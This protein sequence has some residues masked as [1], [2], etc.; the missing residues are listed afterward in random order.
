MFKVRIVNPGKKGSN[1]VSAKRNSKGQ[2]VKKGK[3]SGSR[4]RRRA[5]PATSNPA[6]SRRRRRRSSSSSSSS[7]RRRRRRRNPSGGGG[8]KG[9]NPLTSFPVK[10]LIPYIL[11]NLAQAFAVKRWGDPYGNSMLSGGHMDIS[12]FRGSAWS[13]KNYMIC[14]GVGYL[15]AKI[16]ARVGSLGGAE[17]GRIWWRSAVEQM[18]TRLIWTEAISRMDWAKNNFAGLPSGGSPGDIYDDGNGNRFVLGQNRQW[19]SMQG[20]GGRYG[21]L[22]QA[23]PLGFGELVQA[24]PLGADVSGG[25]VPLGHLLDERTPDARNE[26]AMQMR[27]G[28]RDP[29]AAAMFASS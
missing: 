23:G 5:N 3:G 26:H 7:P 19:V 22:V 6:P 28:S 27:A 11:S 2:F 15:G 10:N 16:V 21:E 29:Y 20:A 4:R 1:N 18:A 24:G 12:G 9:F 13:L 8:S 14:A 17:A 25:F